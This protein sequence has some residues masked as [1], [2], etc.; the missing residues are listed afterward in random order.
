[1]AFIFNGYHFGTS[2]SNSFWLSLLSSRSK[3]Y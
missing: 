1:M 2:S 3:N